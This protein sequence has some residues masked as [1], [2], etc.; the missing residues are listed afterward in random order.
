MNLGRYRLLSQL[1][2]GA[3]GAAYRGCLAEDETPVEVRV[4]SGAVADRGRWKTLVKKLRFLAMLDH[5][6][7]VGIRELGLE[8][9]PPYVVLEWINPPSS[10][11]DVQPTRPALPA[12]SP[13]RE[14]LAQD[15]CAV[16]AAAHRLGL[17]H[18]NLRPELLWWTAGGLKV[19]LTGTETSTPPEPGLAAEVAV[20]CRPPEQ[21]KGGM[22]DAAADVYSVAAIL[23]A[24]L[25][26]RPAPAA[27]DIDKEKEGA[28]SSPFPWNS[29]LPS[30]LATEPSARPTLRAVLEVLEGQRGLQQTCLLSPE[31]NVPVVELPKRISE[32][33]PRE[34]QLKELG[35]FRLL[36]KLGEGGMGAVY[37]AE[38]RTDGT[39]VALKLLRANWEQKP[40][41]LRRLRKEARLLAEINNPYVANLI[42]LNEDGEVPYL[43]LEYV[44][45]HSLG[46]L[47]EQRQRLD[48]ATAVAI[49][50]DVARALVDAHKHGVVHRD[51]KPENILLTALPIG[52]R[53]KLCDFGLARHIL[54]S[55]SLNVTLPG[56]VV[57]T[58]YYAS[59][60]Q[61]GGGGVDS[62]S[63][64]YSMGATLYHCLAGRPPFLADS[65]LA[66]SVMH[67]KEPLPPL[68]RINAA[69]SDGVCRV[70]EKAL[71]KNPDAR[72]DDAE[73]FLDALERAQRGQPSAIAV[74]PRLPACRS[75][76]LLTYDWSWEL[77][78][79]PEQLWPHI[80]NTD[81]LNRAV[82][83]P[84]VHFTTETDPIEG[85]RRYGEFRKAG[86]T[87]VWREYPYEWVEGQR[88]GVLR[89]YSRGVFR[90]FVTVTELRP[91]AGGGTLLRHQVWIEPAG[92]L[93]RLVAALEIGLKGKRRVESVY[94]R[95]D[96]YARGQLGPAHTTDPFETPAT[97]P[98][99]G[100]QRLQQALDQLTTSGLVQPLVAEKLGEFLLSA[101][102]QE[103]ARIRPLA[104]AR[105]LGL[106]SEK[107]LA[108]CLHAA[109]AGVLV[110]LWDLI[111]PVCRIAA[112]I[113][114]TLKALAEHEHCPACDL[115]FQPDFSTA[116]EMIFRVHPQIRG[117][118]LG[119]YCIGG[120]SHSPHVVAQVRV[121]AGE[122]VELELN[123]SV[124]PY[125][126]RGPQLA[127][128]LD[129]QVR[130]AAVPTRWD[131]ALAQRPDPEMYRGLRAGSQVLALTN[132]HTQ[133][134]LVRVERTAPRTDALTA[135]RATALA[136]FR[137]VFPQEALAPG[138]LA[139]LTSMTLLV[140][141]LDSGA[142]GDLVAGLYETFGDARAFGV[143]HEHCQA[144]GERIGR[145]GGTL[146]KTLGEGVLAAFL[147]PLV[148]V[149]VALD[150]AGAPVPVGGEQ[151]EAGQL[152]LRWRVGLH[153]GTVLAATLNNQLDYFGATVSQVMRLPRFI[154]G[155]EVVLTD[156]V[157]SDP[158]VAAL[159]HGRNLAVEVLPDRLPGRT[160]GVLHRVKP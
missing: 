126:L 11:G 6:A 91:R 50:A 107:V 51:V 44:A 124:G 37:R 23:F 64:V 77:E 69:V 125:R 114:D 34:G 134:L 12:V 156:A 4:L 149:R 116:V 129:F 48:E 145:E 61:C 130:A 119:V 118:E 133:E 113:K 39:V 22:V 141:A 43:V 136:L 123:L 19:D 70:L 86:V 35:R 20:S 82:G 131:L 5:P 139:S 98:H 47:L 97:L 78:A 101:S 68:S 74:H 84:A 73:V 109:R 83:V 75:G 115:D 53:V 45:G 88:L 14:G 148:A 65:V 15:L 96:A 26:G 24:L 108:A 105:L 31:E 25:N 60:E 58:P 81:R 144:L 36:E 52:F 138:R 30:M 142:N 21:A 62:R 153:R 103:V 10:N 76:K 46:A 85:V 110:L 158:Q 150:M 56:A 66:L 71:S 72:F 93:G 120:P 128:V 57:G 41:A 29:L 160:G 18:G 146:V 140:S 27:A 63:D 94:R 40:Q 8:H 67:A 122:T 159:L 111:C 100:R 90:W 117:S 99:S 2:A 55:E 152:A 3:D 154:R 132:D 127:F 28:S 155:G 121:A 112:G 9:D 17:V 59:P 49:L 157:A 13:F 104:L 1:G 16:V 143:L 38:D 42:E 89:E 87:N 33:L 92:F 147:D 79:A 151:P 137:D 80:A 7:A 106:D 32:S 54:Q 135:A 95:M 102:A